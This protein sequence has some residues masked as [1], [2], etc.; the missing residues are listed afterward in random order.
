MND[1]GEFTT[2]IID[3]QVDGRTLEMRLAALERRMAEMERTLQ[4][5]ERATEM[6]LSNPQKLRCEGMAIGRSGRV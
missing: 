6:L 5:I 3:G 1:V 4:R 2:V